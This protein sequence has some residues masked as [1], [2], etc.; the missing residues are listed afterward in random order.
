MTAH[1]KQ[2]H[3]G[4]NRNSVLCVDRNVALF[5]ST[6]KPKQRTTAT[7]ASQMYAS[8]SLALNPFQSQLRGPSLV[9]APEDTD[10]EPGN[11]K[12]I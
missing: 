1:E 12:A 11:G 6:Q 2:Q 4:R 5:S 8:V 10:T 9:G 3:E 7:P